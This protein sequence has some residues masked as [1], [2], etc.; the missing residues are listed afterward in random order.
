MCI[1]IYYTHI[2]RVCIYI[3][4][5][6]EMA[7]TASL[8]LASTGMIGGWRHPIDDARPVGRV[9]PGNRQWSS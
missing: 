6:L 8:F 1:Y 2:I 5:Y 9:A 3:Y 4:I 7:K